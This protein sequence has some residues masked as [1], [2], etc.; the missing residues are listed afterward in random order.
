MQMPERE[1]ERREVHRQ[2]H[3]RQKI[4]NK[5]KALKMGTEYRFS[6]YAR[7]VTA[8]V[9][10][11]GHSPLFRIASVAL[12]SCIRIFR[13]AIRQIRDITYDS[14]SKETVEGAWF[15]R[16]FPLYRVELLLEVYG[17]RRVSDVNPV[18]AMHPHFAAASTVF[19][20]SRKLRTYLL[21][22][23]PACSFDRSTSALFKNRIKSTLANSLLAQM[24]FHR[25]RLSS[26]HAN[27][28]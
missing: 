23:T 3:R 7:L 1:A 25:S 4:L 11:N 19:G 17:K 15:G 18:R 14:R 12:V 10:R 13:F 22:L 2:V 21:T 9:T 28:I 16:V 20:L 8:T 5:G 26:C 27:L 6:D 24:S